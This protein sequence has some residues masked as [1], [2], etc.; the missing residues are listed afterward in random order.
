MLHVVWV[1]FIT[2]CVTSKL[3]KSYSSPKT[4]FYCSYKKID[5]ETFINDVKYYPFSVCH[6]FDD[7]DDRLWNFNKLLS[8]IIDKNAPVQ[9]KIIKKP[10][11]P[12][13]NSRLRQ[14]I[15]KKNM[16]CNACRKGKVKWDVYRK[17][18]NL[19]TAMNKQWKLAYFLERCDGAQKKQ[20]F[21]RTIKPFMSD[22]SSSIGDKSFFRKETR[23][24]M[25]RTKYV[26]YLIR[27]LHLLP[28]TS[29]LMTVSR[30]TFIFLMDF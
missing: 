17:Q 14:V 6:I 16:L 20:L 12:Y 25:T 15:H 26:K 11:V 1:T 27:T 21:W 30:L 10:S 8:D 28:T 13:M 23:Q 3:H 29:V 19:A 18:Q 5:N 22:K 4:I 24:L 9:K 7:H 2:S